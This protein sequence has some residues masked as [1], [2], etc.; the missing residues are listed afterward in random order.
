MADDNT[1]DD[2]WVNVTEAAAITG[3]NRQ[4]IKKLIS[5]LWLIEESRRGVRIKKRSSGF[6][7]WLP[8]LRVYL[9][10]QGRRGPY[11]KGD[12]TGR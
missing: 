3:Y 6:D 9:A 12:Q 11:T 4:Y 10:A 1:N 5:K 8:D 7:I 2:I